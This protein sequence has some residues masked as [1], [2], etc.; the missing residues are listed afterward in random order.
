MA[1]DYKYQRKENCLVRAEFTHRKRITLQVSVNTQYQQSP[2]PVKLYVFLVYLTLFLTKLYNFKI[3]LHYSCPLDTKQKKKYSI[4]KSKELYIFLQPASTFR[5][6]I[7]AETTKLGL[8][9][10]TNTHQLSI[11]TS[12]ADNSQFF[13]LNYIFQ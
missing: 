9:L 10:F 8:H 5:K 12:A 4:S 13:F 2:S 1:N 3:E 11:K 7:I 6:T